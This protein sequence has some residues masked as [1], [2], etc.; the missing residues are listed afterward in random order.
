ILKI[1]FTQNKIE[2]ILSKIDVDKKIEIFE[3]IIQE[4]RNNAYLNFLKT[5]GEELLK[6]INIKSMEIN[7]V[8]CTENALLT[9]MIVSIV[10]SVISIIMSIKYNGKE[11]FI[12]QIKPMFSNQNLINV[13]FAGIFQIKMIHIIHAIC[14]VKKKWRSD[15]YER[16]SDRGTYDYS[17]E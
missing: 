9:S 10:S 15:K 8:I 13:K 12:Y 4:K 7:I 2:K 11:K 6:E 1:T 5:I 3:E 14:I 17:Y 16:T